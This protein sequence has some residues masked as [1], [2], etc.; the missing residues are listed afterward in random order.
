MRYLKIQNILKKKNRKILIYHFLILGGPQNNENSHFGKNLFGGRIGI[1]Y[2]L[3]DRQTA[4]G[5]FTYQRSIYE[6]GDPIFLVRR[7]DSFF[8]LSLGY[9]F[10]YNNQ[11]SISPTVVYN[12]NDSN[13]LTNDYDR[14]EVM[15]TARYDF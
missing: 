12:D 13:I 14:L 7:H 2:Q 6:T 4:F 1:S 10:Q 9:R 15:V 8:D 11:L 5:A 3:S